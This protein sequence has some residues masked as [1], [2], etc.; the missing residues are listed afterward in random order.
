M[1]ELSPLEATSIFLGNSHEDRHT[2][3]PRGSHH[4]TDPA[5]SQ[6]NLKG[7]GGASQESTK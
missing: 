3:L 6:G 4:L 5:P 1:T 7:L 2:A